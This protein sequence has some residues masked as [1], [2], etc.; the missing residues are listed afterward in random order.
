MN[1]KIQ[2]KKPCDEIWDEMLAT[3]CGRFCSKCQKVVVD[4]SSMPENEIL[5]NYQLQG[6]NLCVRMAKSELDF[7][8]SEHKST[9]ILKLVIFALALIAIFYGGL[10]NEVQGQRLKRTQIIKK[11]TNKASQKSMIMVNVTV[12]DKKIQT[13]VGLYHPKTK[14]LITETHT[15]KKG[16]AIF[17]NVDSG[18]YLLKIDSLYYKSENHIQISSQTLNEITI[19]TRTKFIVGPMMQDETIIIINDFEEPPLIDV[20]NPPKHEYDFQRVR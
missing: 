5:E 4:I 10:I 13:K 12:H 3:N 19:Q 11:G 8:K 17:T 18:S 7:V 9:P 14:N 6:N 16:N 15:D 1:S 20:K 2:I